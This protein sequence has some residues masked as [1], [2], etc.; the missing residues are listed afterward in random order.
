MIILVIPVVVIMTPGI[1]AGAV[2]HVKAAVTVKSTN[3][4]LST[5]MPWPAR[6]SCRVPVAW[7]GKL[8]SEKNRCRAPVRGALW[9]FW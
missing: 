4:G 8:P 2:H 5:C 3:M 6:V 1:T 7:L 9:L